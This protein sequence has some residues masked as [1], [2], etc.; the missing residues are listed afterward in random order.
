VC[1]KADSGRKAMLISCA[2]MLWTIPDKEILET[3]VRIQRLEQAEQAARWPKRRNGK[4]R[5][6]GAKT[7]P[8]TARKPPCRPDNGRAD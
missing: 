2:R 3:M 4:E 1:L 6:P 8:K 7:C 5:P